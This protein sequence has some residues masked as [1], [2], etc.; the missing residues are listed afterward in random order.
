MGKGKITI[1]QLTEP[2]QGILV[3]AQDQGPVI[4][5]VED[6]IERNQTLKKGLGFGLCA[7][8]RLMDELTIETELGEGTTVTA[9]KWKSTSN[10][11]ADW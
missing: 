7:V 1:T 5:N 3:V 9:K 8:K 6:A 11:F 10:R 4:A 2:K